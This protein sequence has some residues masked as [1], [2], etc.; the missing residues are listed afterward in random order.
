MFAAAYAALDN[1]SENHTFEAEVQ[2]SDTLKANQILDAA[3]DDSQ[4]TASTENT[5]S[6]KRRIS[7]NAEEKERE[8]ERER[9]LGRIYCS[10]DLRHQRG[11]RGIRRSPPQRREIHSNI[12]VENVIAIYVT[13]ASVIAWLPQFF[14]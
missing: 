10:D 11:S 14:F 8:R 7:Q 6:Y 4:V 1:V 13:I 3:E 5:K 9:G 2:R 12:R